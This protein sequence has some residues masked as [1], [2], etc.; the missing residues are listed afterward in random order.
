[1][2]FSNFGWLGFILTLCS[3]VLDEGRGEKPM[4]DSNTVLTTPFGR[5]ANVNNASPGFIACSFISFS[6]IGFIIDFRVYFKV[7]F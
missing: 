5:S 2:V 3:G 6:F 7:F 1:M 4:L